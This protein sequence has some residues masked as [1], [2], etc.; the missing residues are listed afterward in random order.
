[1]SC[2]SV[3]SLHWH[4]IVSHYQTGSSCVPSPSIY[5]CLC[6]PSQHRENQDEN[7]LQEVVP[8]GQKWRK[9]SERKDSG[10]K[11]AKKRR[12]SYFLR[13]FLNNCYLF[14]NFKCLKMCVCVCLWLWRLTPGCLHCLQTA[15]GPFHPRCTLLTSAVFYLPSSFPHLTSLPATFWKWLEYTCSFFTCT[16]SSTRMQRGFL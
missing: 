1:M 13:S 8:S 9:W 3:P 4:Q 11:T 14:N 12:E 2:P 6:V 15:A 10:R 16:S 7:T 5:R